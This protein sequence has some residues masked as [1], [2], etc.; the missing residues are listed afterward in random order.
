MILLLHMRMVKDEHL[1]D[2]ARTALLPQSITRK[3]VVCYLLLPLLS[4]HDKVIK[5]PFV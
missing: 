1:D 5:N 4:P 3:G 2:T